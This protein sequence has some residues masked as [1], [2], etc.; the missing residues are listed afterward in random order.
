M[1]KNIYFAALRIIILGFKMTVARASKSLQGYGFTLKEKHEVIKIEPETLQQGFKLQ[2]WP[3][4]KGMVMNSN[5]ST[6]LSCKRPECS[7]QLFTCQMTWPGFHKAQ[8]T[9]LQVP[10][11]QRLRLTHKSRGLSAVEHISLPLS[12]CPGQ[13]GLWRP[14]RCR[15][16]VALGWRCATPSDDFQPQLAAAAPLCPQFEPAMLLRR[17]L[18]K[19]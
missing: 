18:G 7:A 1:I 10:S 11:T 8:H 4:M 5:Y 16:M 3:V 6:G 13:N 15:E 17:L 14:T 9:P 19:N 12:P 2:I